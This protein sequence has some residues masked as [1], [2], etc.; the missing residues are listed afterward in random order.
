MILEA[1]AINIEM[2]TPELISELLTDLFTWSVLSFG[3]WMVMKKFQEKDL[4]MCWV[5]GLRY[6]VLARR[7]N[8][9]MQGILLGILDVLSLTSMQL[10]DELYDDNLVIAT[11]LFI[12]LIYIYLAICRLRLFIALGKTFHASRWYILL[13]LIDVRIVLLIWGL[14]SKY[15]PDLSALPVDDDE[16]WKAGTAP[17]ELK[18]HEEVQTG[19]IA[20]QVPSDKGLHVDI[21]DR[22]VRDFSKKRYLLKDIHMDIPNGTMVLLL[23][24]SG[25][26]KTTFVNAITGYE[27]ANATVILNGKDVYK[28]YN[29]IKYKVGMVPQM[30]LIR[31]NDTVAQT[32]SDAAKM[33]L[34]ADTTEKEREKDVNDVMDLLGLTAGSNGLVGKKSGGQLR[35][36]SI[37]LEMISNPEL[38]ILD[39]PDSGLDGVI[40]KEIFGKLRTVADQGSIVIAIT[41]TP[42]RVIDLFDKVIVLA[43]DSGRVGRLAFYGSPEEARAFFGKDTMEGIVQCVNR[44]EEG[45]DGK[46]DE[47]IMKYAKY[48]VESTLADQTQTK[49]I[50]QTDTAVTQDNPDTEEKAPAA[51]KPA[52]A[53]NTD[54]PEKEELQ[55]EQGSQA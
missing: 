14:R 28:D 19:Q 11:S 46:A 34:P 40:A 50:L 17:V 4:W 1:T 16:E 9:K 5:P 18:T 3:L 55:D 8:L 39:E 48:Y 27:K 13:M 41:H 51:E 10:P 6:Y 23:G 24:G 26:G 36:I 43:K 38:F 37:A 32:I 20:G 49:E 44:E 33:R 35:R 12:L 42:D 15:Q 22:S 45:G 54:K 7:M 21:R 47:M 29:D 52:K 2:F 30:N 53:Q 31:F 25:A